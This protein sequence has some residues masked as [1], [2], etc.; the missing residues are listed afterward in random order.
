MA[1]A[2]GISYPTSNNLEPTQTLGIRACQPFLGS[3]T[4]DHKVVPWVSLRSPSQ[5]F[6]IT[7]GG[8]IIFLMSPNQPLPKAVKGMV[9][10]VRHLRVSKERAREFSVSS[11]KPKVACRCRFV[12]HSLVHRHPPGDDSMIPPTFTGRHIL[13]TRFHLEGSRLRDTARCHRSF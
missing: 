3:D 4:H 10:R 8:S 12:C 5:K 1:V 2:P 11:G 9:S 13:L 6:R 7:S